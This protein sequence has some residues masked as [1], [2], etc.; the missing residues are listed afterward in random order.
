LIFAGFGGVL[1]PPQPNTKTG[2]QMILRA[3][4]HGSFLL[5]K[6]TPVYRRRPFIEFRS[7]R[8]KSCN[9]GC[10]FNGLPV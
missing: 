1:L 5:K 10:R 4:F 6:F 2:A 9:H 7:K 3:R 8:L